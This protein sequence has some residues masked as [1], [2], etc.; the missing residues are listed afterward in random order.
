MASPLLGISL[1]A[2]ATAW[3]VRRRPV[4]AVRVVLSTDVVWIFKKA[5][6]RVLRLRSWRHKLLTLALS[7]ESVRKLELSYII[8]HRIFVRFDW[9]QVLIRKEARKRLL[10]TRW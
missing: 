6:V 5:P 1:L 8:V 7:T 3:L 4:R 9:R 2:I 10:F